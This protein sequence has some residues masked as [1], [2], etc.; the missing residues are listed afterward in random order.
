VFYLN[1]AGILFYILAI[2]FGLS[3]EHCRTRYVRIRPVRDLSTA[4]ETINTTVWLLVQLSCTNSA[5]PLGSPT[6]G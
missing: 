1:L 6:D 2:S 4:D 3:R 5:G